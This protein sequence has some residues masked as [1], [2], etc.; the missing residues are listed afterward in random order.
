MTKTTLITSILAVALLGVAHPS[1]A[2]DDGDSF[3]VSM[4]GIDLQSAAGAKIM[5]I[6][7]R[8]ASEQACGSAPYIRDLSG[9][10]NWK[11]CVADTVG[12][13]VKQLNAPMVT[14]AL[15]GPDAGSR[16]VAAISGR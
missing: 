1:F 14:V 15:Q 16:T 4:A 13:A 11:A 8:T 5:L 12:R 7:I 3:K 2:A 9:V 10:S 6:R